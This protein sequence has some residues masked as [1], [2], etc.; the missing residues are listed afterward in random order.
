M[1]HLPWLYRAFHHEHHR[2]RSPT[3]WAAYAFS[4]PEALVQGGIGALI[5]FT[6]PIHRI[7]FALF[8][9]CQIAF[10]VFGH[11]GYEIFPR[12][13][14]RCRAGL[15]LNSVT[16]HAMHH[17]KFKANFGLYFNVWDRLMGT[18]HPDYEHR[19]EQ[20]TAFPAAESPPASDPVLAEVEACPQERTAPES[21]PV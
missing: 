2:S 20:A 11:C 13:F 16:A 14:M 8:M 5:A 10:N 6:I 9:L 1:M 19:F 17:E 7:S 21:T 4:V 18:N 12:W 3:P 15:F